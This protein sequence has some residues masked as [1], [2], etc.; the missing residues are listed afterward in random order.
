MIDKLVAIM[1]NVTM[2]LANDGD[3]APGIGNGV[4]LGTGAVIL[5]P[6]CVASRPQR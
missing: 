2:G 5:G 1:H 3:G 4:F 6:V